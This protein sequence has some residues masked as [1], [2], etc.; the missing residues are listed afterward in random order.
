MKKS[1]SKLIQYILFPAIGIFIIYQLYKDQNGEEILSA[2][3]NDVNYSWIV[4]SI[5]LGL[6]SHVSRALRWQMLIEPIEKKTGL[7]NTFCAVMT[8]YLANLVFPRMGEVSRCGVLSKYERLS[9]TRVVG[10]VVAERLTDLIVLILI[11][12]A[13]L[14]IQFDFLGGFLL[15][16]LN[17]DSVSEIFM[18]PLFYGILL[19]IP[20][21]LLL[22]KRYAKQYKALM[23]LKNLMVKFTEGVS[24]I[25]KIKNKPLF[26]FHTL[27]I[28][29]M[30]FLMIY[31]CF[32]SMPSTSS[33]GI[34]AGITILLTGSL[35]MIAPVQ[36]GIGAWHFMVIATLKLYGVP[37]EEGGVFA[38]VVH[39]AQN[40]MIIGAGLLAFGLLP[41][42]NRSNHE[43]AALATNR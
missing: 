3:R 26:V 24:S 18:S 30:Y 12:I 32:F 15:K 33:L 9:F 19:L 16:T 10:T 29:V 31:V 25:K 13:V 1:V 7:I 27:F 28:W 34:N 39:A 8:G 21:T 17:L 40:L 2:L 5:C 41:V 22:I 11:A 36:G 38:L 35:G 43:K 14:T 37:A 42:I 6:L 20:V 4:F 23:F